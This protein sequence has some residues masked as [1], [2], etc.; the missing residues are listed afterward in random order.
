MLLVYWVMNAES[1]SKYSV[2]VKWRSC[3]GRISQECGAFV[4]RSIKTIRSSVFLFWFYFIRMSQKANISVAFCWVIATFVISLNKLF[5]ECEFLHV[6]MVFFIFPLFFARWN[7]KFESW[8]HSQSEKPQLKVFYLKSR[9]KIVKTNWMMNASFYTRKLKIANYCCV[10]IFIFIFE[11]TDYR[12]VNH[13]KLQ[14]FHSKYVQSFC[15]FVCTKMFTIKF[16][17]DRINRMDE[18]QT[19]N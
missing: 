18:H 17:L 8:F 14:F 1:R 4:C 12:P 2:V 13:F 10:W 16:D 15:W 5:W 11:K 19:K 6:L 3:D 7:S 9:R